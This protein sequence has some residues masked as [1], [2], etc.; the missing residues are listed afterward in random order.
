M[1]K[2]YSPENPEYILEKDAF[3]FVQSEGEIADETFKD[4]PTVPVSPLPLGRRSDA[5]T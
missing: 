1:A 4:T 2:F 3:T 5:G